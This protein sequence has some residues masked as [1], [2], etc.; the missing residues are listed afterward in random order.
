MAPAEEENEEED[1]EIPNNED[2]EERYRRY[3][4]APM[5]ECSDVEFWQTWHHLSSEESSY[6]GLNQ[7]VETE[8]EEPTVPEN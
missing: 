2:T 5:E 3:Q 1:S 8:A 4:S 7:E 6:D